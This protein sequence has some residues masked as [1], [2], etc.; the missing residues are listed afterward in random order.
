MAGGLVLAR[1][2]ASGSRFRPILVALVGVGVI[3]DGWVTKFPVVTVPEAS[4]NLMR[5]GAGAV[6][7]L[8][9]GDTFDDLEAM[10]RSTHH[11]RS[12]VNGYS[13]QIPPH[14]PAV[15][16]GLANR[17]TEVLRLLV[18]L[19]V[20]DVLI[21]QNRDTNGRFTQ[22]VSSYEGAR[23]I[24]RTP[25]ESLYRLSADGASEMASEMTEELGPTI[26]ILGLSANVNNDIVGNM[27]DNDLES[28]WDTG[29]QKRGDEL[30]I[31]LGT[32]QTIGAIRL[33]L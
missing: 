17:D 20:D 4:A 22:F 7:E 24:H 33:S 2:V 21:N 10:Y 14:Y 25:E 31:D 26:P 3:A 11:G 16:W 27:I 9:L 1:A 12:L 19:G 8:P 32:R 6:L 28:R 13:G 18:R 30:V 29:I 15:K 5:N 23:Q